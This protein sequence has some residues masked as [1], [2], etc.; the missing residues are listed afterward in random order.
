MRYQEFRTEYENNFQLML[1]FEQ[2]E[3]GC[4]YYCENVA[5]LTEKY[6]EF[7]KRLSG[8]LYDALRAKQCL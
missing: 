6:P 2:N 3:Y 5:L 1:S 4:S 7:Y 8:D